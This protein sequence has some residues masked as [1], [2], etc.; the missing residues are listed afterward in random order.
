M[1]YEQAKRAKADPNQL[2][3]DDAFDVMSVLNHGSMLQPD[4]VLSFEFSRICPSDGNPCNCDTE[5]SSEHL[6]C[7]KEGV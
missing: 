3:F 2:S 7:I 1:L 4:N 5:G 6:A